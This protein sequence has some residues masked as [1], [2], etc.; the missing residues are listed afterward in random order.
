M[1]SISLATLARRAADLGNPLPCSDD[2]QLWFSEHPADLE[3]AKAMW[4]TCPLRRACPAGGID[5]A[6][7]FAVWGGGIFEKGRGIG[8]KGRGGA[9][10]R[11]GRGRERG[12]VRAPPGLSAPA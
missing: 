6:E 1:T 12:P 3:L 7:P 4:E 9:P 11:G 10:G 2:T 5:R 8:Y